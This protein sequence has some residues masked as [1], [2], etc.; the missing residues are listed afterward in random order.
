MQR[1]WTVLDQF[2]ILNDN[3]FEFSPLDRKNKGEIARASMSN[4]NHLGSSFK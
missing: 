1:R 3:D 4:H 2:M